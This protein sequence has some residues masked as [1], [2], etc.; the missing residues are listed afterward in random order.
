MTDPPTHALFAP[1]SVAARSRADGSVLLDST[2]PLEPHERSLAEML[3]AWAERIPEYVLAAQRDGGGEWRSLTYGEARSTTDALAQAFL[4]RGLGPDRPIMILSGNS[5][6]HLLVT[7]AAYTAGVPVAPVSTAY[8]LMSRDHARIRAIAELIRPGLV[9]ADGGSAF[10]AALRAVAREGLGVLVARN[11]VPGLGGELLEHL[12]RTRPTAKV[13]E[14]LAAVTPDTVAKLLFTSGSTG[15]PKGV[16]NTHRMLCANQ[17][18]IR[19]VWP[20]LRTDP[21][22]LVDWLPWSHTFGGNHN[23]HLVLGNG[24]TIHID[25]SKPLPPL[26]GRTLAAL[27]DVAPTVYF[28]VPAGYAMLI[29]EL[30]RDP[31]LGKIFFSR[32]RLLFYAA[33]SLPEEL[34]QRLR[35]VARSVTGRDVPVTSS[36]GATETAPAVTSAHYDPSPSGCIGVPLPGNTLKLTPYETKLEIRVKGPN[37]TPGYFGRE[38]LTA[39]AFDDEGY[40]ITGDAVRFVDD[41]DP[42]K[43]LLFDG[44]IAEDFKLTSG[45]W[46]SVGTLRPALVSASGGVLRDAVIA[47]HE[48]DCVCALGWLNPAGVLGLVGD[49]DFSPGKLAANP[50]VRAHLARVLTELNAAAGSSARVERLLLLPEPPSLDA[51]EITDKGYVNQRVV[52]DRRADLVAR[53]YAEP[54][55][56]DVISAEGQHGGQQQ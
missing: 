30:E 56:R 45:T 39:A 3:R 5:I 9:F 37:V 54:H 17:Q 41:A 16:L 27:K 25:D 31:E 7:L 32:L 15:T 11:P 13:E 21:P 38:D 29:P 28:N 26:F 53:L 10:Q 18:M 14:A 12:T 34:W 49:D 8:S 50:A 24:G 51:G 42:A 4:D 44:R 40:Y 52:L 55:H 6:E 48:R 35:A 46:V 20:F 36:W 2:H 19:Q 47:G 43:G 22:V 33:A 1:P 23:L